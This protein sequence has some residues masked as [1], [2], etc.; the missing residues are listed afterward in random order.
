MSTLACS[1]VLLAVREFPIRDS[2]PPVGQNDASGLCIFL[3][4]PAVILVPPTK[5][6]CRS[7]VATFQ[8]LRLLKVPLHITMGKAFLRMPARQM[9]VWE[10]KAEEVAKR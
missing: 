7:L 10:R 4:S 1:G 3:L 2:P 5:Q 8:R 9:V 6:E